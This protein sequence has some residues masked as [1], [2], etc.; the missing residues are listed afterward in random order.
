MINCALCGREHMPGENPPEFLYVRPHTRREAWAQKVCPW[1][2]IEFEQSHAC[3]DGSE[4]SFNAFMAS[5]MVTLS[6]RA[7]R[8]ATIFRCEAICWQNNKQQNILSHRCRHFVKGVVDGKQLCGLHIE[9][10]RRGRRV[11]T[12]PPSPPRFFIAARN[13]NE[14]ASA[15]R[16]ML[17]REWLPLSIDGTNS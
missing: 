6:K 12:C 15:A 5:E 4:N 3:C 2:W 13:A 8:G 1:C 16:A 14:F 17:P 9:H 7:A 11:E 10:F